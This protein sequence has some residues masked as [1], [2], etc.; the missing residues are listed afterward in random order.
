LKRAAILF[1]C[2]TVVV[3]LVLI[4]VGPLAAQYPKIAGPPSN[5]AA[6]EL[7]RYVVGLK[8]EDLPA[9]VVAITKRRILDTLGVAY[10]GYSAPSVTILRNVVESEGG[11]PEATIIG[12]GQKTNVVNATMVNGTMIRYPDFNDSFESAQNGS[13][14][15]SVGIAEALALAERQHASGKDLI[16]ATVLV[17]EVESR[18]LDTFRWPGFFSQSCAASMTASLVS[19]KLLGL[20]VE[21]MAN[22]IGIGWSHNFTLAGV[23]G[24]GY[25]SNMKGFGSAVN[26]ASG[27]TA[28]LL[29]QKGFTGPITIIE[30]Y[31]QNF[32]KNASLAPLVGP[33]TDFAISKAWT[34]LFEA[35]HTSNPPIAGVIQVIKDHNIK[36]DQIE[37][38]FVRG[39]HFARVVDNLQTTAPYRN[40]VIPRNKEDADHNLAYLLSTAIMEG[41]VTPDQYAKEGWKD[42][43]VQ[44]LMGKME[45]Q[46][47]AELAKNFPKVWTCIVEITTKDKQVYTQRV[48]FTKG[49][50]Q[51]P[52]TDQ[53]FETKFSR[54]ATKLMS[55]AQA[56]Q[57]IKTVYDLDK[58]SDVSGLTKLLIA[59]KR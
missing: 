41:D 18:L 38:V 21:Q 28:A 3:S 4:D 25:T 32:E 39:V 24:A 5:T 8:Y 15:P 37:K 33:R 56:D 55:Q 17:Y 23:Y 40:T 45:F 35:Y 47:D 36:P 2:L 1:F 30:S 16:L 54:M 27:V 48:D 34:K 19:G 57:I 6:L 43:K 26:S 7:A 12:S 20:N 10:G 42:P 59:A 52:F 51:N 49:G 13:A 9:D 50:P 46:G 58:L 44:E 22:A 11:T 14:H 29:A 53:E 31:Q